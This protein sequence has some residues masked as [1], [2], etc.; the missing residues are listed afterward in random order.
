MTHD[1][2]SR[3]F[4]FYKLVM[5]QFWIILSVSVLA[6]SACKNHV[7]ANQV[8]PEL[9]EE[10]FQEL[11]SSIPDHGKKFESYY[12]PEYSAALHDAW[13]IP[14]GGVGEIG[15]DEFL[16]YFVCGNDPCEMH[17]GRLDS[18]EIVGDTAFVKFEIIH[19]YGDKAPHTFK[20]VVRDSLWIIADY[21]TTL[22]EMKNYLKSQRL[23]LK[24]DYYKSSAEEILA[25]PEA[26]DDWKESVRE[27]LKAVDEYF[28]E[29]P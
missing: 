28:R 15:N 26:H 27:E 7:P 16:W 13:E 11:V 25:N 14:D 10:R 12:T 29:H 17:S 24:S 8:K 2:V 1:D 9:T 18:L 23:Y 3:F 21:D 19:R 22:S 6:L 4:F 5:K 20:L